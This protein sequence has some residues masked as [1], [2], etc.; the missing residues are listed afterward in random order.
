[1]TASDSIFALDW[2]HGRAE[3][4]TL[5]AMLGPVVFRS[6]G[7]PDV[8]PLHVAPWPDDPA[9]PGILRRLR[10]DWPCVPF[11]RTDRLV[12]PPGWTAREPG[13][14]FGHGV[15][16]HHDWHWVDAP[17]GALA[18]AI[19]L[20]GPVAR[21]TRTVRAVPDAPA[22]E[23]TLAIEAREAVTLPAALH[24]TLR[25][26][27]LALQLELPPHDGAI[28]Y[29]VP[30]EPGVSRLVPDARFASLAAAPLAGGGT[31]DLTRWPLPF[32]TEELLQLRA[33]RGPVG[34]R[35]LGTPWT[36]RLDWDRDALPDLMV[37]VSHRGRVYPPWNGRH[38]ALGLE[39]VNGPF[40][41]GRIAAPPAGHPF[42]DRRG[43]VLEPGRTRTI[44]HRLEAVAA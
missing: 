28:S 13:D 3:L 14:D 38:V 37:W 32:D 6:P 17:E 10:G 22:L 20:D 34:L 30:A 40:D 2:P 16:S 24:P 1:M 5:G 4:Q 41:L 36:I 26:E 23:L 12:L 39:P 31:V 35:H 29:P 25:A 21:M 44:R 11:G 43:L 18:L 15:A 33:P 9:L 7:K 8:A 27:G 19:E 42:A